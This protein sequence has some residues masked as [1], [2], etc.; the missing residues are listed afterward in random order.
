[1]LGDRVHAQQ[2]QDDEEPKVGNLS[3]I[4]QKEKEMIHNSVD[5]DCSFVS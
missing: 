2:C 3:D 5:R 4:G 1:M